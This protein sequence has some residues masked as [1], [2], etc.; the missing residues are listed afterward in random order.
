ML[1]DD[2]HQIEDWVML[3]ELFIGAVVVPVVL[4]IVL[5]IAD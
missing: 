4:M 1:L 2:R 5:N 3:W